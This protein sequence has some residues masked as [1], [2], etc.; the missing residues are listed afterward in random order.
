MGLLGMIDAQRILKGLECCGSKEHCHFGE[1]GCPF[2]F[3]ENPDDCTSRLARAALALLNKQESEWIEDSDPGQEY[4]TTWA[5]RKCMHSI[6]KPY[7]WNPYDS[8][9]KYCMHCGAEMRR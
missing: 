9:Y 7:I 1:D 2:F 4:G 6:H 8:G 3:P 5:C